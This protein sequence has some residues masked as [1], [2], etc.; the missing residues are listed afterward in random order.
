LVEFEKVGHRVELLLG[1]L[2]G[3]E[4]FFGHKNAPICNEEIGA[5]NDA[6]LSRF[7]DSK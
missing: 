2:E 1:H 4:P 5:C 3:I 7:R 6:S